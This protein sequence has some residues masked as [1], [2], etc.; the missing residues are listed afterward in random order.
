[1]GGFS[2]SQ[3]KA[4]VRSKWNVPIINRW[5]SKLNRN[6]TYFGLPGPDV[7]DL[8]EW[9]KYLSASTGVERLRQ[10]RLNKEDLDVHRLLHKNVLLNGIPGFQL[11]RGDIE[12]IILEG[13]DLDGKQPQ[14][15]TGE[16]PLLSRFQFDLVNLDYLGGMGNKDKFGE[17][18]RI[19]SIKKL[20]ERQRGTSFLLLLTLNVRDSIEE[21]ITSYLSGAARE[22]ANERLQEREA[23]LSWYIGLGD[24][25]KK[26][27]L[28]ALVPMFVRHEAERW[29]F[30]CF[31]YP[32]LTYEGTGQA[33]MVHFTFEMV[34]I[35]SVLHAFSQQ[36]ETEV[37]NMPLL[38]VVDGEIT[39]V[40]PEQHPNFDARNFRYYLQQLP[41]PISVVQI[42]E[43][44]V[45]SSGTV[46]E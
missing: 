16:H 8:I 40:V 34:F 33:R 19:R 11:L 18:R 15:A 29:G 43:A 28:K 38:E 30:D 10:G 27:K 22:A 14:R 31:S 24:G 1:M 7:E 36:T 23:A 25:M 20:I 6:L 44:A 3:N 46:H 13:A 17:S 26:H 9:K 41:S 35:S 39:L 32:P 5:S 42:S 37:I 4:V 45:I 21:E 2:S 12:T